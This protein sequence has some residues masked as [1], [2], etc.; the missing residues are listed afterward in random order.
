MHWIFSDNQI[1]ELG[2]A[3]TVGKP[4]KK[5]EIV[6]PGKNRMD[7]AAEVQRRSGVN[8]GLCWHCKCCAGG[9]PFSESMDYFPNQIIRLV[10]LGMV[11]AALSSSAI[12]ICVGCHT[13]SSECPQAIDMA[14]VM[15]ALRQ[16][17]REDGV[18]EETDILNFH[19]EVLNSIYRYGRTHK[20]EIMMRY[21][22]QKRDWLT[23]MNVGLRMLSKR[24]LDLLPSRIKDRDVVRQLFHKSGETAR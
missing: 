9:C 24:K 10:Q 19:H 1:S 4:N 11:E 15:D 20:L 22:L 13:C 2:N 16:M 18:A 6:S 21:K 14:A 3:M 5:E 17:A 12:W 8:V 23:D 7:F